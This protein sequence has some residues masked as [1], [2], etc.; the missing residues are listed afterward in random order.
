MN[1]ALFVNCERSVED[2]WHLKNIPI[3][4]RPEIP[5]VHRIQIRDNPGRIA[6]PVHGRASFTARISGFTA[7]NYIWAVW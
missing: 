3:R 7:F 4:H 1:H 6:R 5:R 2:N